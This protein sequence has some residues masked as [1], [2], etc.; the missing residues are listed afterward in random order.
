MNLGGSMGV[1][2]HPFA[3][4][5]HKNPAQWAKCSHLAPRFAGTPLVVDVI[6]RVYEEQPAIR[7]WLILHNTGSRASHPSS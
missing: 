5:L 4:L 2:S 1:P 7:K 6:Y 3:H